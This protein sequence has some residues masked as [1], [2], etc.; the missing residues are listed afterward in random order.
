MTRV[1]EVEASER[2]IVSRDRRT[3]NK[4]EEGIICQGSD[5]SFRIALSLERKARPPVI[6]GVHNFG[7]SICGPHSKAMINPLNLAIVHSTLILLQ[8]QG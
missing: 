5:V 4:P 8:D 1:A 6:A 7:H 2:P 3:Q